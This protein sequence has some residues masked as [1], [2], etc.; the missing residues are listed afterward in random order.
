MSRDTQTSIY[1]DVPAIPVGQPRARASSFGGHVRV[2][3]VT[4]I[5]TSDGKRKPHPIVAFKASVKHEAKAAYDGPP[6]SGPIRIDCVFIFP[7]PKG[8]IWKTKPMPRVP[9]V[10]KPD[11][12]NVVKA[13]KDA[14]SGIIWRDDAQVYQEFCTKWV[15][16]G[17]EQPRTI[18]TIRDHSRENWS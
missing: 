14:L 11:T 4:S 3:E 7:R 16:A 1:L 13:V 12:D 5:R 10:S 15:A 9:H 2:H 18:V 8:M 17:D 6:L